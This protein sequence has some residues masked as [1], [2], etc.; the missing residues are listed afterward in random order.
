MIPKICL[1][2]LTR[3]LG[4]CNI[5]LPDNVRMW[6]DIVPVEAHSTLGTSPTF[7]SP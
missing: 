7:V 6:W 1:S 4:L 5:L 3:V 2:F